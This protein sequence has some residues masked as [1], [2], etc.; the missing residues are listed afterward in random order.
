[1]VEARYEIIS[2]RKTPKISEDFCILILMDQE[3][4]ETSGLNELAVVSCVKV[5]LSC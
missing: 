1:M 4:I 2:R 5:S 3:Q